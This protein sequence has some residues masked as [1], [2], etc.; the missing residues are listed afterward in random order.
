MDHDTSANAIVCS[1]FPEILGL[2]YAYLAEQYESAKS[3]EDFVKW[4][5]SVGV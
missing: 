2:S 3:L 5:K 4:L 1:C